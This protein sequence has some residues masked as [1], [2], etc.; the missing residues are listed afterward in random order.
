MRD[1]MWGE[2]SLKNNGLSISKCK[3]KETVHDF[4][5]SYLGIDTPLILWPGM[6]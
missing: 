4:G 3:T 1:L 5:L 6:L 2:Q